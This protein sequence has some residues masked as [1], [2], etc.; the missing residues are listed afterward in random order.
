MTGLPN[1]MTDRAA[2]PTRCGPPRRPPLLVLVEGRRAA[3]FLGRMA[4]LW[5]S[6]DPRLPDLAALAAAGRLALL[7]IGGGGADD[8]LRRGAALETLR[9]PRVHLYDRDVEPETTRRRAAIAQL[10]AQPNCLARLTAKRSLANYLH[11]EALV[12]A[13]LPAIEIDDDLDVAARLA[14]ARRAAVSHA[15]SWNA[16]APRSRRRLVS[17]MKRRLHDDALPRM[18][19][20]WARQRDP[21]G[22]LPRWL[23]ELDELLRW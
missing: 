23:R 22:D 16:L 12:A 4:M 10:N 20:A 21:A 14:Q 13:G 8:L 2:T 9:L 19:I 18:T 15:A 17:R 5:R 3:T 7:P 6:L 1:L 11:P